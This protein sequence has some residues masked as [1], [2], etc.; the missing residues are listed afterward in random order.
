MDFK[1]P[2]SRP[3]RFSQPVTHGRS[4][5]S[6][7]AFR[8]DWEKWSRSTNGDGLASTWLLVRAATELYTKTGR[9]PVPFSHSLS[10]CPLL[11]WARHLSILPISD[12]R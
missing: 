8:L 2:L 6:N 1:E 4:P 5:R 11:R 10:L 3:N 7:L 12:W 9:G